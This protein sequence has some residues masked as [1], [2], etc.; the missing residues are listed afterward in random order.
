MLYG[1]WSGLDKHSSER[2][3]RTS[4]DKNKTRSLTNHGLKVLVS[5]LIEQCLRH[6]IMTF[7]GGNVQRCV[8][9]VGGTVWRSTML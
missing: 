1:N 6:L 2:I 4:G 9:I 7:L 8:E 3:E 5:A